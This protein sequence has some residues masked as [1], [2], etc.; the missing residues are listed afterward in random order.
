[1]FIIVAV[2]LA[3]LIAVV[4]IIIIYKRGKCQNITKQDGLTW[5]LFVE[6]KVESLSCLVLSGK[7]AKMDTN[8]VSF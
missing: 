1:M 7:P 2:G 5:I 8:T 4:V 3:L 6:A